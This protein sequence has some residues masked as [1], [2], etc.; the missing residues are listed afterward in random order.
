MKL[1]YLGT[2]AAEAYPAI[3]CD[4]ENCRKAFKLKGKNIRSRAQAIIDN[5]L[6]IDFGCDTYYH[7]RTNDINMHDIRNCLVTHIHKDH[8]YSLEFLYLQKAYSH[9]APDFK[10]NLYGSEDVEKIVNELPQGVFT[11]LNFVKINAFEPFKVDKYTVTPLK[12]YHGSPNPL[13]YAVSDGEKTVLYGHDTDIFPDAT[14]EY[15]INNKMHFDLV[16]LDCTEGAYE[17]LNYHGHMCLGRNITCR[18]RMLKENLID[19]KTKVVLNHFSHNGI[20]SLY[21][22]FEPIAAEKGFITSYDGME[23]EA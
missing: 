16:S 11:F 18:D 3:F 23:V 6:L 9:P 5:T 13:I 10:L 22:E 20:N 2:A 8:F 15:M 12:A 14:W 19:K 7:C 17:D 4:C 1:K 21:D